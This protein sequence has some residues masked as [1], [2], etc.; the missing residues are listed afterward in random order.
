MCYLYKH[1]GILSICWFLMVTT[2]QLKYFNKSGARLYLKQELLNNPGFPFEDDEVLKVEI[3]EDKLVL[4]RPEWWEILDW[5]ELP[6]VW[7]TL[8]EDI[9]AKVRGAGLAPSRD[10]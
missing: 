8:P 5:D 3:V 9:K 10:G 1:V 2:T 7:R 6:L 4:S